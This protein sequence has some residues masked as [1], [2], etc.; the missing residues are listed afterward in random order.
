[1]ASNVIAEINRC[2]IED[3]SICTP[4]SIT[5]VKHLSSYNWIERPTATIAVPGS[6]PLWSAPKTSKQLQKDSGLY[7]INQNQARYPESPLEPLFRALYLT[8]PAFDIRSV[9]VVT[10]RNNIRKLLA[11][12]NSDLAPGDLEPFTIGVEVIGTTAL[13]G[14]DETAVTRFIAPNEFRGFGHEFEKEYTINQVNDSTGHHRIIAYRFG[15][16]EFVVRYEAD[17]YVATDKTDSFKIERPQDDPLL[18][19]MRGL[20]LSPA[21][22]VS[23]AN[24]IPS[25]LVITEE[26]RVVP[27]E[28]ILEIKTRA[29]S[30]PL[31]IQEVAA[32]L[33]VSQTSKLV[34]AY[35]NRGKFQV[36]QVEDVEAQVKRWEE[37]N[38]ND[39]KR[40]ASLI[41][42]ISNL[43]RQSG[44]KAT[45]RYEGGSKLLLYR[46]D[47]GDML[48]NFLYSKW[49]ERGNTQ[50]KTTVSTHEEAEVSDTLDR[51]QG[52]TI[53][54]TGA[55]YGDV[56]YSEVISYGVDKGFRQFFRRMPMQL[57]QYHLLCDTLDSLAID[58]TDGRT[59]RDIMY[60]MRKGKDEWDPEERR[61]IRGLKDIA[62]D[63]A[64]RLLYVLMQS[65]VVDTN[66]AYNAALF[67]VSHRRIF[68]SRTRKMVREA[69][70]ENCPVSAKQRAGLNKWPVEES[71]STRS[72]EDVTTEPEDIFFDSDSSF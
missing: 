16:L 70:E 37:L 11:F 65:N 7:Y 8:N 3:P 17:G 25:E 9:D 6:P 22:G 45:V 33:W 32:Q 58:V 50:A 24:P 19:S 64:F 38:Q 60:D 47:K 40:L 55:V 43:A 66:M 29:I 42:T 57:S 69:L 23:N 14:R 31:P 26:G 10:D 68:R 72:E 35:H 54:T 61:E 18:A 62:R 46:A 49:E 63:S 34:R 12:I 1:M 41:K 51:G 59:I 39:L 2:N 71:S 21:T 20:S 5:N 67:V 13:F 52:K 36:P 53:E 15:G 56:P 4:A 28:S 30:R 27:P 48:P 44:G